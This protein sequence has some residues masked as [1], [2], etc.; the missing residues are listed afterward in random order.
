[1]QK[2][3]AFVLRYLKPNLSGTNH[4]SRRDVYEKSAADRFQVGGPKA[5]YVLVICSLL[6]AIN[7]M[8]RLVMSV[9]LQPMKLD[10]V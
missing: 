4:E 8:D 6:F 1:M 7:Y 10:L 2:E 9:V 5:T 3:S